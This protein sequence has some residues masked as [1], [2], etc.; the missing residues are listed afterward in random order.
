MRTC[1]MAGPMCLHLTCMTACVVAC[2]RIIHVTQTSSD[3]WSCARSCWCVWRPAVSG[4]AAPPHVN[5]SFW[6]CWSMGLS[7]QSHTAWC[8]SQTIRTQ[9]KLSTHPLVQTSDWEQFELVTHSTDPGLA[10]R[11][12]LNASM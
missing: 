1:I 6:F 2:Q 3:S 8:S 9:S 4:D 7:D 11:A 12:G 10:E 5:V